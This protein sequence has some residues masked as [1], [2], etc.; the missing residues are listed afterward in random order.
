MVRRIRVASRGAVFDM[1][2]TPTSARPRDLAEAAERYQEQGDHQRVDGGH[3]QQLT[4]G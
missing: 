3:D 4:V 2:P 1:N